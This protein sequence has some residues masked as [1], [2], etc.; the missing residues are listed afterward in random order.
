MGQ[1]EIL[2]ILKKNK[3]EWFK[4]KELSNLN[5][6]S[7]SSVTCCLLKLRKCGMVTYKEAKDKTPNGT[8]RWFYL[9]KWGNSKPWVE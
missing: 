6:A 3:G 4:S 1:Q 5:N 9:Y 2:D 8:I 7:L